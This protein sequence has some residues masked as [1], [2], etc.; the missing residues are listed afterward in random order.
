MSI[1][2]RLCAPVLE[3]VLAQAPPSSLLTLGEG[4]DTVLA[5]WLERH[6]DVDHHHL[7]I[8]SIERRLAGLGRYDLALAANIL[9][10]LAPASAGRLIAALR[11]LHGRRLYLLVPMGT[12]WRGQISHWRATDLIA[13]GLRESGRYEVEGK[14]VRLYRHDLYDYKQTPDWL[15]PRHWAHPELWDKYRW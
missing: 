10:G 12:G 9:E 8:E 6:P 14:P 13:Y 15:N 11:D 7:G 1:D 2:P 5:P 3:R 4:T